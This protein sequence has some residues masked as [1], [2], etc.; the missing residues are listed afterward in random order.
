[1]CR[2]IPVNAHVEHPSRQVVISGSRSDRARPAR[3]WPV[4]REPRRMVHAARIALKASHQTT[5]RDAS[6]DGRVAPMKV[7][8]LMPGASDVSV[9]GPTT[10]RPL[11]TLLVVAHSGDGV[12]VLGNAVSQW[13]DSP[14]CPTVIVG[15]SPISQV[16]LDALLPPAMQV[17][18]I[19]AVQVPPGEDLR[20][21]VRRRRIPDATDVGSY[22]AFRTSRHLAAIVHS[23]MVA[24]REWRY[25][26][27]A[28]RERGVWSPR[29]WAAVLQCVLMF[30]R[31]AAQG[32]TEAEAARKACVSVKTVSA[33]CGR[34]FGREWR[35]LRRLGAWEPAVEAALRT[36]RYVTVR[37][38]LQN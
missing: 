11:G 28:L 14:W 13:R 12:E 1:M 31:A 27:R 4:P 3:G 29:D 32:W 21:A 17:A 34:Y 38:P 18:S 10:L 8:C 30:S 25:L 5:V 2:T 15:P 22:I 24:Q 20:M 19:V 23:A 35:S 26:R 9:S 36:G 37:V 16:A 6:L 7:F 33:R